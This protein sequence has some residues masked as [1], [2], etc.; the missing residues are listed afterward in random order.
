MLFNWF[1][2]AGDGG[3]ISALMRANKRFPELVEAVVGVLEGLCTTNLP[4]VLQNTLPSVV[5]S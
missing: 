2:L 4:A 1:T 3:G 5:Q